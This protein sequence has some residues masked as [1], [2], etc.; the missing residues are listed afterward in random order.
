V[1][2]SDEGAEIRREIYR[3]ECIG[4]GR[5]WFCQSLV[6]QVAIHSNRMVGKYGIR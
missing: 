1:N 4:D 5:S 2:R 6:G 3:R